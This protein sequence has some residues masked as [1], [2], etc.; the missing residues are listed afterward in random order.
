VPEVTHGVI[1]SEAKEPKPYE[2]TILS[3]VATLRPL[4]FAQGDI[5]PSPL[6]L[7][8]SRSRFSSPLFSF[9]HHSSRSAIFFSCPKVPGV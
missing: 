1:L 7:Y 2:I 5:S 3:A 4:R 6:S 9:A 8:S